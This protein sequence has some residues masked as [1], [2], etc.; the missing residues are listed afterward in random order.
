MQSGFLQCEQL[1]RQGRCE[2]AIWT[3]GRCNDTWV[4]KAWRWANSS[5]GWACRECA[6][7][8]GPSW[9]KERCISQIQLAKVPENVCVDCQPQ[10]MKAPPPPPGPPPP[11]LQ[12]TPSLQ[13]P[14]LL[15]DRGT[16]VQSDDCLNTRAE[17]VEQGTSVQSLDFGKPV[18]PSC[19]ARPRDSLGR[20]IT[21]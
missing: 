2:S 20:D 10:W 14:P 3:C 19:D 7:K 15:Q 12:R 8:W 21:C 6:D 17:R 18:E 9:A 16:S 5:W 4:K 1:T 13:T 11:S